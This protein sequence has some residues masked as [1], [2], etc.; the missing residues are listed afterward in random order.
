MDATDSQRAPAS[1][2]D[3]AALVPC[4]LRDLGRYFLRLGA[5]GFGGPIALA[6]T[7]ERDLVERR[8]W[9]TGAEY[10]EGLA[11]SQLCP[12]PLAG[13][14]AM[15]LGWLRAGVLGA[16][17]AG[18]LFVLPSF[19]MVVALGALYVRYGGLGWIQGAFYGVGAGVIAIIARSAAKLAR[20]TLESDRLLWA[21][22]LATAL[23][24]VIT[25]A[26]IVWLFLGSGAVAVLWKTPPR[27]RASAHAL[28]PAWLLGGLHGGATP[29][30]LGHLALYFTKAG[31]FVFGS[32]LAI[33]PFLHVGVVRD[34]HWLD[35]R[36]F[37]DAVAVAMITPGPVV[38]TAGFIGFLTAGLAGST[39]AAVGTFLPPFLFVALGARIMRAGSKHPRVR[40]FVAGVTASAV[41][42]IAGAAVILGRRAIVDVPTALIAAGMALALVKLE[43]VPEPVLIVL[44]G[45]AGVLVKGAAP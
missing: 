8:R 43:K 18:V 1:S 26:E 36:Q 5:I 23:A 45:A 33:V 35:D 12:G 29:A 37:L 30:T 22:F 2:A 31:A 15:Y 42:A 41:G 4:S 28:W 25:Q 44:T 24:T 38:I 10:R 6:G 20:R 39:V 17:V 32:G 16:A 14:L 21:L 19:A 40:A 9:F 34:F 13:Q 11:F 3:E 7:M 27:R